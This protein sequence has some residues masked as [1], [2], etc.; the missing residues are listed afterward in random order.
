VDVEDQAIAVSRLD[1]IEKWAACGKLARGKP[2]GFK[3]EP[4]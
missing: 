1:V 2:L 3:Q 4:E